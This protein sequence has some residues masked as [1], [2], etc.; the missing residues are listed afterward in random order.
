[1]NIVLDYGWIEAVMLAGVRMAGFIVIAPPFSYKAFPGQVKA[2]IALALAL[3]VSP[4][5]VK[6][7]EVMDTGPFLTAIVSE[8][9]VG[10]VLGFLVMMIFAA[11]QTAGDLIDL[12][13]GFQMAQAFDPQMQIN[14][15]QFAK[16]FSMTATAL[17]LS[18]GAYALI[19]GGIVRTFVTI[20]IG[21]GFAAGVPVELLVSGVSQM[22]LSAVQIAGPIAIVLFLADAGLGLITKVAPSMNAFSLGF[23]LKILITL[24]LVT[25]VYAA[26]PNIVASLTERA[27][28]VLIG[29]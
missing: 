25:M 7:Y 4:V 23:P 1:M 9:L 10:L 11:I 22:F 16:L 28:E 26:L 8:L 5:V 14:G 13:G 2:L 3:A 18:S 12:F 27:V 29:A 15:A 24:G 20:P 6:D 17:L 21:T 19:I